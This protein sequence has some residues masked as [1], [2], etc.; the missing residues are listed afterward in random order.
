MNQSPVTSPTNNADLQPLYYQWVMGRNRGDANPLPSEKLQLLLDKQILR[1]DQLS[2]EEKASIEPSA[3]K[4]V[5]PA[6]PTQ[7]K[8]TEN[9]ST[10]DSLKAKAEAVHLIVDGLK[11][12]LL[13]EFKKK[14]EVDWEQV[15][16][17]EKE[18]I[19]EKLVV[20]NQGKSSKQLKIDFLVKYNHL[21]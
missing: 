18:R 15:S 14:H 11:I 9:Q 6:A 4:I 8:Q 7:E 2:N 5:T 3:E 19:A 20:E 10:E 16:E 21:L 13:E 12:M 1:L 17:E